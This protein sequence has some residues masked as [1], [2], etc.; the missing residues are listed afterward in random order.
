MQGGDAAAA[1]DAHPDRPPE[2]DPAIGA[3][4]PGSTG[5]VSAPLPRSPA[6]WLRSGLTGGQSSL[7]L[8][9]L[10]DGVAS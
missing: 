5:L 2:P 4:P 7:T 9:L 10:F 6:A 3:D 8:G 1:L